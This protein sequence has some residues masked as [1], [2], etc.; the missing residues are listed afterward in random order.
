MATFSRAEIDGLIRSARNYKGELFS[1]GDLV[2]I[3]HLEG[4]VN[5][6]TSV[7]ITSNEME[8]FL[9]LAAMVMDNEYFIALS[10]ED[11]VRALAS[12]RILIIGIVNKMVQDVLTYGILDKLVA[13]EESQV[14]ESSSARPHWQN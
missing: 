3:F 14:P 11:R 13:G 10:R 12:L 4:I 7:Q 9:E 5:P 6:D 8:I 2:T 1:F